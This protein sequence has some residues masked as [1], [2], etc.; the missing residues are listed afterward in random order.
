MAEPFTIYKLTILNMLDK[1]DFPLTN[2]QISNFFLE[3]DYT[4]YFRVQQVLSDHEDAWKDY[5]NLCKCGGS[6][7][8]LETL[9]Y[10][11]LMN[12]FEQ[13]TVEK[14]IELAKKDLLNSRYM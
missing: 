4:D 7:S 13:G 14:A 8:Y 5:L 11:H 1:V 3:Q 6:M 9:R 12:P 2:T 10:A